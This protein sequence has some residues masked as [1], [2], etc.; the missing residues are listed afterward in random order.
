MLA[1]PLG[2]SCRC[3]SHL[4]VRITCC[5]FRPTQYFSSCCRRWQRR[6]KAAHAEYI[7]TDDKTTGS[8]ETEGGGTY[9][10]TIHKFRGRPVTVAKRNS[11]GNY[12]ADDLLG[13]NENAEVLIELTNRS[14]RKR[15]I[16]WSI[17][18]SL[19]LAISK[20]KNRVKNFFAFFL[21]CSIY[22]I[23]QK[24]ETNDFGLIKKILYKDI[25]NTASFKNGIKR[26]YVI[27]EENKKDSLT[28][29]IKIIFPKG[30][31]DPKKHYYT[32]QFVVK[33]GGTLLSEKDYLERKKKIF[34][35]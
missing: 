30:K 25:L 3:E 32:L 21:I 28:I 12:R 29:E 4:A 8:E 10:Y 5:N 19:C 35:K 33:S 7:G 24:S 18:V 34:G 27:K 31:I 22:L 11:N 20:E 23:A 1:N 2:R 17:I 13:L 9:H 15:N 6:G 16:V 26:P 14:K